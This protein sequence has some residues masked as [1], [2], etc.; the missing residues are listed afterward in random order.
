M[1]IDT[2]TAK[3]PVMVEPGDGDVEIAIGEPSDG[4]RRSAR[5]SVPQAEMLQHALGFAIAG[6]RERQR[7]R[8]EEEAGLAGRLLD[9]EFRRG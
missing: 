1:R 4:A 7:L 3:A 5:L 9:Q 8:A 2:K 6:I